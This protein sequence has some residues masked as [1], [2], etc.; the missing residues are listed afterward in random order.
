MEGQFQEVVYKSG[1]GIGIIT[2]G[3]DEDGFIEKISIFVG[4]QL[5]EPNQMTTLN[6]YFTSPIRYCGLQKEKNHKIMVFHT[7]D[8]SD[9]FGNKS[10]YYCVHWINEDRIGN[11]YAL[12]SFRDFH[13]KNGQWK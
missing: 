8:S 1:G 12:G 9:L 7:G 3:L 13:F 10:F 4:G 5:L 2:E 6:G 11:I